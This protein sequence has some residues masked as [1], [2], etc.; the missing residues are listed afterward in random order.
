MAAV[1]SAAGE[2]LFDSFQSAEWREFEE[3]AV[4]LL[5]QLIRLDTQNHGDDGTEIMAVNLLKDKFSA[6]GVA[7]DIVEPKQGRGNIIARI[8]GDGSSGKGALCLSAHLDT[9]LAPSEDWEAEGWKHDPFGGD[10]DPEDGCLYGRGTIDMKNM[11]ALSV[12]LLCFIKRRNIVLSRD[13]IFAGLAD[14]ERHDAYYGA[15]YMVENRPE[16]VEADIVMTEVGGMSFFVDGVETFPVMV[17]EKTPAKVKLIARGPGGHGSIYHK[18]NPIGRIGEACHKL[19]TTRLPLRVT[20]TNQAQIEALASMLSPVKA[21]GIRRLLSPL[22]SDWIADHLLTADQIN[23]ILPILHNTANP[24]IIRGGEQPNQIPSIV[25][26]MI[27]CRIVPGSTHE[28]LLEDI[29]SVLGPHRFNPTQDSTG[30]E[31]PPELELEIDCRG[32]PPYTQ[33][34]DGQTMK[35]ALGVISDVIAQHADGAPTFTCVIPGGTDLAY[36]AKHPTK[37]PVCLGFTPLR[38]PPTINFSQLFHGV[39]ERIPVDGF[40]WGLRVLA[41]VTAKLCGAKR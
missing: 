40:K 8:N 14:E 18:D 27:D 9:V 39:N 7:Y 32:R 34:L 1:C 35:E 22:F 17:G 23:G 3:E 5:Q 31:V 21:F 26:A 30:Q 6:A 38:L 19:S 15:Q 24:V 29:R 11:A 10:I 2:L 37:T 25:W 4:S 36:Y 16:L 12:S 28:E 41:D 20:P 33:D 13:L